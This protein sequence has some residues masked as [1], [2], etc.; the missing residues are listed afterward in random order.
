MADAGKSFSRLS[1][2]TVDRLSHLREACVVSTCC[3]ADRMSADGGRSTQLTR[4]VMR[5][6]AEQGLPPPSSNGIYPFVELPLRLGFPSKDDFEII[7]NAQGSAM[8]VAALREF[9][10]I[11]RIC[12]VSGH[13][14]P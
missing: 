14:L 6:H 3:R 11:S 9:P 12:R 5:R 10:R 8:A 7:H 2:L 13:L 4:I 1:Y